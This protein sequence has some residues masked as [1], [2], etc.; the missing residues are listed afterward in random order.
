ME[1]KK[2]DVPAKKAE[3]K[4]EELGSISGLTVMYVIYLFYKANILSR[5]NLK[6]FINEIKKSSPE[7]ITAWLIEESR[8]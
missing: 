1:E 6:M 4:K 5:D 8:K 7:N 3:E 2:A